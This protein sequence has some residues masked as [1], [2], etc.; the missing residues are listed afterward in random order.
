PLAPTMP[1]THCNPL[2]SPRAAISLPHP[3]PQQLKQARQRSFY[4]LL[5]SLPTRSGPS[6]LAPTGPLPAHWP[7]PVMTPTALL[8]R[9]CV[10]DG[11]LGR[12]PA[13][14]QLCLCAHAPLSQDSQQS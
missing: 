7:H 4:T 1:R 2:R 9:G 14:S 8:A 13:S 11:W 6:S 12:E 3:P 5:P 10:V